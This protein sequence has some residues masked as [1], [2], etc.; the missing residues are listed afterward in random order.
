M[1]RLTALASLASVVA[2]SAQAAP[3]QLTPGEWSTDVTVAAMGAENTQNMTACMTENDASLEP[4]ELAQR[5]AGGADCTSS[6]VSQSGNTVKFKLT[7]GD[8]SLKSAD[9]TLTHSTTSFTMSGTVELKIDEQ[10]VLPG[11]MSIDANRN[12][13]CTD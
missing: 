12:G 1:I 13:P 5:F 8:Q 7:C 4:T 10:T 11:T 3:I 6:D 9:L 2:L